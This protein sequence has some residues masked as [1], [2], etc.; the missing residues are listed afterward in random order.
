MPAVKVFIDTNVLLYSH[1]RRDLQKF[2]AS[3]ERL[4]ALATRGLGCTNLQVLNEGA[5]LL[6]RKRWFRSPS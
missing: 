3:R 2:A 4:E 5:H 1:D 6:L